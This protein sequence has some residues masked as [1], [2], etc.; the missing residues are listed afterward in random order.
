MDLFLYLGG[1]NQEEA[2]PVDEKAHF[3][4]I[5]IR[6]KRGNNRWTAQKKSGKMNPR[7]EVVGSAC[8]PAVL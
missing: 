2:F 4:D 7:V 8:C 5:S 3:Y 6:K 1:H